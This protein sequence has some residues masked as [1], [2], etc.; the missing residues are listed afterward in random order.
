MPY[1]NTIHTQPENDPSI[2]EIQQGQKSEDKEKLEKWY[3]GR[4]GAGLGLFAEPARRRIYQVKQKEMI[5]N[6][7]ALNHI[8]GNSNT[9]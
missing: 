7:R 9:R 1:S 2:Q 6:V 8:R 5:G 3:Q 4:N